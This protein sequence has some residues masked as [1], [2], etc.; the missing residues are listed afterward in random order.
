[1]KAK[2][3]MAS[4]WVIYLG[5]SA[6]IGIVV[7]GILLPFIALFGLITNGGIASFQS[8]PSVLSKPPLAQ[9]T[10]VQAADGTRIATLF[11]Q[12][13]IEV[14]L[15]EISPVMQDAIIAIEDTRFY[16]HA[17]FDL[18]GTIRA[19]ISTTTGGQVQGG[20]TIT[21]Q[22]VKNL[23]IA[24][25][26]TDE[27]VAAA[28]T[29]T[30]Q[31]KLQEIRYAL[32]L[33][34]RLTKSQI[35]EG[36]LNIAYFGA[37]AYGIEA[38]SQRY[39]SK[40]AANLN[41]AEA[42]L[43]AGLVQQPYGYDPL[44]FP[45][46][47]ENRRAIVLNRMAELEYITREQADAVK[48]QPILEI[49]NPSERAN[50]CTSSIAPFYCDY[51]VQFIRSNPVFGNTLAERD[52]LLR[53]GGLVITTSIDLATQKAAQKA[54]NKTIP[55]K[56]PSGKAAAI[57]MIQP[58]TGNILAM[59]QNRK[60]G[61]EGVGNT[62]YNYNVERAFGGTIGMQAGSTF[63]VFVLA[64][65]IEQGLLS[66]QR[67][68]S[69]PIKTF[70][71]FVNC[72]NGDSFPPYTARNSTGSGKFNMRE[73]T[74]YSVNTYFVELEQ[75][76]GVCRPVE[77]AKSMGVKTGGGQDIVPVPSFV[78]GS[79]EVTPLMVANAYATFAARGLH[80]KP[81]VI[82]Q[83]VDRD[84]NQIPVGGPV[85]SQVIT[86]EVADGVTEMLKG[87]VDGP[88]AG[89]TGAR[90]TLGRPAAGKTGTTNDSAAV[91]FTGYTPDIAA[92]VWVGDPRGGFSFPMKDITINGVYYT[93]VFGSTLPGPIWQQ[94]MLVAHKNLP[95]RDFILNLPNSVTAAWAPIQPTPTPCPE[96]TIDPTED[97]T[98]DPV[99]EPSPECTDEP[100]TDPPLEPIP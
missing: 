63:K 6:A 3:S 46:A 49:L 14:D 70:T 53:Q 86:Q 33:E 57:T 99:I 5:L 45:S 38:A 59:A 82:T 15:E 93:Q 8:I 88:I 58:G 64:A 80:C 4:I 91:W 92:A 78:L 40:P 37:G 67:I 1:M 34:N 76:T 48:A 54:V 81:R 17:G 13:R 96:P 98:E 9:Q 42:S 24:S 89:R 77:I 22:Y 43:L 27:E 19:I 75:R 60:W 31:R 35:L 36:Y 95:N 94:A 26:D 10:V 50:G 84:G 21:Q 68:N 32:A 97:P 72:D 39:F 74:A 62:T 12:N 55:I 23:L 87:V 90:M 85:C 71:K 7:V 65:A 51:V 2:S 61:T 29:R 100:T 25:A 66:N 79:A 41:L 52:A 83:V 18:R 56:D 69:P 11:F 30:P 73:G 44:R 47:A 16:S 20:S 28:T